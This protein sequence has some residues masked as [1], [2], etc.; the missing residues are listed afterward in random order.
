[1]EVWIVTKESYNEVGGVFKVLGVFS[2]REK[3]CEFLSEN[4]FGIHNYLDVSRTVIDAG[5]LY[6]ICGTEWNA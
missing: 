5:K 6:G 4:S 1:M 2:T 3:A